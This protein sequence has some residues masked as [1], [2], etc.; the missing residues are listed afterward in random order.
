LFALQR[1][2]DCQSDSLEPNES[3][4]AEQSAANEGSGSNKTTNSVL[5]ILVGVLLIIPLYLCYCMFYRRRC[6]KSKDS[7]ADDGLFQDDDLIKLPR[8]PFT[9]EIPNLPFPSPS[10][11]DKGRDAATNSADEDVNSVWVSTR[12]LMTGVVGTSLPRFVAKSHESSPGGLCKACK[13]VGIDP[14][15]PFCQG[16]EEKSTTTAHS[17]KSVMMADELSD[18]SADDLDDILC[19]YCMSGVGAPNPECATCSAGQLTS[20][21]GYNDLHERWHSQVRPQSLSPS[22][23]EARQSSSCAEDEK[24]RSEPSKSRAISKLKELR[25]LKEAELL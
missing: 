22:G 18:N 25:G 13:M 8:M 11:T 1:Q 17:P 3:D 20:G 7:G 9:D 19:V 21:N 2:L 12:S 5:L 6:S 4:L 23:L 14:K 16:G 24:S 15:C 10:K